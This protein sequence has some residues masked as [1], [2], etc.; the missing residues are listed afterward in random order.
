MR[1]ASLT[2]WHRRADGSDAALAVDALRYGSR[3]VVV[4]DAAN[5]R[6]L[7]DRMPPPL[8]RLVATPAELPAVFA[9]ADVD[10]PA[11]ARAIRGGGLGWLAELVEEDR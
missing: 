9:A 11:L 4:V 2:L 10:G 3:P 8:H 6:A 7:R 5:V 1:A